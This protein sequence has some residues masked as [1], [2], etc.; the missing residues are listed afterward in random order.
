MWLDSVM[1]GYPQRFLNH[2][3]VLPPY[4]NIENSERWLKML[5]RGP[6][7][8][9]NSL[10]SPQSG[11]FCEPVHPTH[12]AACRLTG[13]GTGHTGRLHACKVI[14]QPYKV[15]WGYKNSGIQPMYVLELDGGISSSSSSFCLPNTTSC[16]TQDMAESW[17][18][19]RGWLDVAHCSVAVNLHLVAIVGAYV[20]LGDLEL[21]VLLHG[22]SHGAM[23]FMVWHSPHVSPCP[24]SDSDWA[25]QTFSSLAMMNISGLF[26]DSKRRM[27]WPSI[28]S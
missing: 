3:H 2:F 7:P 11:P 23:K 5:A 24:D 10:I 12:Q 4:S 22:I 9:T 17:G 25:R 27:S 18:S 20:E 21:R 19:G 8:T 28:Y 6:R 16:T 14:T 15:P 1:R 13:L 26:S